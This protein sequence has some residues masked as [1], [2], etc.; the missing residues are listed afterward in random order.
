MS[1][2]S[3]EVVGLFCNV[4][5]RKERREEEDECKEGRLPSQMIENQ[6]SSHG[7]V[8]LRG[9]FE[10]VRLIS[11]LPLVQFSGSIV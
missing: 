9:I 2:Q 6:K 7:N 10:L 1:H 3:H 4:M 5:G 11:S 8:C